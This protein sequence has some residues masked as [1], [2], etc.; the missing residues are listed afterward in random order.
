MIALKLQ[1]IAEKDRRSTVCVKLAGFEILTEGTGLT[2]E[3]V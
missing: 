2:Q 3:L 1:K